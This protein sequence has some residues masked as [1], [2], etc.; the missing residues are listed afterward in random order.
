MHLFGVDSKNKHYE[1]MLIFYKIITSC[2]I[3]ITDYALWKNKLL[4]YKIFK[5]KI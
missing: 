3:L 5:I 1:N 4:N 2:F